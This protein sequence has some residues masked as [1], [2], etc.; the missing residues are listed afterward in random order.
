[1]SVSTN[2]VSLFESLMNLFKLYVADAKLSMAQKLSH[3]LAATA[4][5]F[6]GAML[7][8]GAMLFL[9]FALL[10]YLSKF[11][12][13]VYAS[14][15]VAGIYALLI[16]LIVMFRR[17]LVDDPITRMVTSLMLDAPEPEASETSTSITKTNENEGN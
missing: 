12:G 10:L 11:L 6:V 8:L 5:L 4:I 3:A 7:G 9:T 1:M 15:A 13:L 16:A 14:M 17:I 2:N